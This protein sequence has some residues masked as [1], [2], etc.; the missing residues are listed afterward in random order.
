MVGYQHFGGPCFL[1][2]QGEESELY[3]PNNVK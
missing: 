2:L 3:R 1:P